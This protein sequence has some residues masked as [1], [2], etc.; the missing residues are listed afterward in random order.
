MRTVAEGIETEE[1]LTAL[2]KCKVHEGQGY[3]VS[4]PVMFEEFE[5][6]LVAEQSHK[7]LQ[8]AKSDA[9]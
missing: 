8:V 1:Q 3:L 9:A 7:E 5:Q 2:A 4:R 6:L